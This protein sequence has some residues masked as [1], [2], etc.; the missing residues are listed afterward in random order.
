[1]PSLDIYYF[2]FSL[3]VIPPPDLHTPFSD[4]SFKFLAQQY[5]IFLPVNLSH[6]KHP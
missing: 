5:I 6:G 4:S 1:M 3:E 2:A